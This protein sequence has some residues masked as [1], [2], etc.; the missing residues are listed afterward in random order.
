MFSTGNSVDKMLDAYHY[1]NSR[2]QLSVIFDVIGTPNP[3][4]LRDFDENTSAILGSI[5]KSIPKVFLPYHFIV[6]ILY[7]FLLLPC[8]FRCYLIVFHLYYYLINYHF[9]YSLFN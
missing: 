5:K 3:E 7:Y 2:S 8:I 1:N 6:L 9:V 4:D